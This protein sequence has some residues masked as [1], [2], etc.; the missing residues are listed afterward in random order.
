MISEDWRYSNLSKVQGFI[1]EGTSLP[2]FQVDESEFIFR[3]E[4]LRKIGSV[5]SFK[6]GKVCQSS[7]E[8]TESEKSTALEDHPIIE[9]NKKESKARYSFSL[10]SVSEKPIFLVYMLDAPAQAYQIG[11]ELKNDANIVEVFVSS[12]NSKSAELVSVLTEII[13]S[14]D[15]NLKHTV[16]GNLEKKSRL[17]HFLNVVQH[18][19][20]RSQLFNLS[21]GGEYSRFDLRNYLCGPGAKSNLGGLYLKSENE[22]VDHCTKVFHE[23]PDTE[24]QQLYKGVLGGNSKA[25]FNGVIKIKENCPNSKTNQLNRNLIVSKKAEAISRPQLEILTDN[26][27]ANHGM[28]IGSLNPNEIFYLTSR[29]IP[30]ETAHDMLADAFVNEVIDQ[31]VGNSISGMVKGMIVSSWPQLRGELR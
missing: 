13:V 3:V 29:G 21:L 6:G 1:T 4:N 2:F 16:I 8:F 28:T 9:F 17:S 25:I 5:V 22:F 20:S 19:D 15:T 18:A 31:Y 23:A 30:Q 24:S 12:P 27:K 14:A 26:V 7:I 10:E 11:I